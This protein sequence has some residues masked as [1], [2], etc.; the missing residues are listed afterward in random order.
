MKMSFNTRLGAITISE[1]D[2]KIDGVYFGAFAKGQTNQLLLEAKRQLEEYL[3]RDRIQFDLPI[4]LC[5]T[6]FQKRIWEFLL[7]VPYGCTGTYKQAA[8]YAGCPK[9][10]RAAG[11]AIG[12]NPIAIIVPCHRIIGSGGGIT[13]YRYGNDIKKELLELEKG[14]K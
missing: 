10:A 14:K 6:E 5:G 12:R 11:G 13:G 9:G 3:S 2:G 8:E 1:R 4:L 7:T